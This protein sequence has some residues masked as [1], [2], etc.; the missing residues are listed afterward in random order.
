MELV[1]PAM[2]LAIARSAQEMRLG[3]GSGIS[4]ASLL[5]TPACHRERE[6]ERED[7]FLSSS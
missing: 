2:M 1:P 7:D 3:A 6:R 5:T 4:I